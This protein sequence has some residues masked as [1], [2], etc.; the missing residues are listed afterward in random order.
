MSENVFEILCKTPLF[1]G[2][3]ED[4]IR[5]FFGCLNPR[6]CRYDKNKVVVC[7][8]DMIDSIGI[9]VKGMLAVSKDTAC[10][11]RMIVSLLREGELFG[12]MA[13]FSS[14]PHWPATVTAHEDSEVVFV[15]SHNI[16]GYCTKGCDIHRKVVVNMLAILSNK[17][18]MLNKKLEYISIKNLRTR[19]CRYI[20]EEYKKTGKTTLMISMNRNQ[21]ADYLNVTR[22][23]LSRELS[24]MK[25]D[26]II[27]FYKSAIKIEDIDK[28]KQFL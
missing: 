23:A 6:Y 18:L 17:A 8:G 4:E 11:S 19:I 1:K 16:A 5:I 9:V 13:A 22:P 7:E 28:L 10:G 25:E 21:L 3:K 26:G 20:Y 2:L 15:P 12:E 24:F 27:D 14:Y